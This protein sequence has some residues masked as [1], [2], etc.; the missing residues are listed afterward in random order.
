MCEGYEGHNWDNQAVIAVPIKYV[1]LL[2]AYLVLL[3]HIADFPAQFFV[4]NSEGREES[5]IFISLYRW[6]VTYA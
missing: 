5:L 6:S 3:V 1:L 2:S 4:L